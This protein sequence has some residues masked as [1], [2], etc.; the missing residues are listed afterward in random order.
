MLGWTIDF[1]ISEVLTKEILLQSMKQADANSKFLIQNYVFQENA[2]KGCG[3]TNTFWFIRAGSGPPSLPTA[4]RRDTT[5][6]GQR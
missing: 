1:C 5:S 3:K 4:W 6:L 2:L